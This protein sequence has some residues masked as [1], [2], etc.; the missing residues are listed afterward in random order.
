MSLKLSGKSDDVM[1]M[2]LAELGMPP[3]PAAAKTGTIAPMTWPEM[4]CVLVP[5]DAAG[6]RLPPGS[7]KPKMW[8]DLR[9]GAQV[10]L[11]RFH[12]H[13]GAKQPQ[14]M[15]I[16]AKKGQKFKGNELQHVGP[17]HGTVIRRDD[18][19]Q[20]FK[21]N[22]ESAPMRIGIWWLEAAARGGPAMLPLVNQV[23]RFENSPDPA[24]GAKGKGG[25]AAADSAASSRAS[26]SRPS[27]RSISRRPG[28]ASK[29]S[30]GNGTGGSKG[31]SGG[32]RGSAA[33]NKL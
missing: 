18:E 33:P 17:G 7:T 23:P 9:P 26:S 30:G 10:A 2:L 29:G 1:R 21:L 24:G 8:L 4:D 13:Q 22:I 14:S 11:S 28:E 3:L 16:G 6:V 12:N 19:S 15:H 25:H 5:Y 27:S 20:S 32:K 31:S